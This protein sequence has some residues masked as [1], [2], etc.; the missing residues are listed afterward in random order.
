[1]SAC[2]LHHK[3]PPCCP[4]SQPIHTTLPPHTVPLL[5]DRSVYRPWKSVSINVE[6]VSPFTVCFQHPT[7]CQHIETATNNQCT[8]CLI[9][10]CFRVNIVRVEME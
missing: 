7:V 1:M 2:Y 10:R 8:Y 6:D 4:N 3:I 9:L 5:T